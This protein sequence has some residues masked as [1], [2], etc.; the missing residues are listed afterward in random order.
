MIYG[1]GVI[2]S[3]AVGFLM[4][5][6]YTR[7]LSPGDYGVLTLLQMTTDVTAIL[8]SAGTTAGVLRFYFKATTDRGRHAVI[9]TA[10]TLLAVLNGIGAALLVVG[11]PTI[12]AVVFKGE[13]GPDLIRIAAG[14][15]AICWPRRPGRS[16]W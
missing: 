5:P 2:L 4:L 10:L 1:V 16:A 3:R 11:A 14:S 13:A 6:V 12:A 7:F 15:W 8:L 9:D